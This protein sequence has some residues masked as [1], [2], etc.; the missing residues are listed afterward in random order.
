MVGLD[1]CHIHGGK[2]LRGPAHPHFTTGRYSTVLP[3]RLLARYRAAE[4][5]AELTPCVASSP[6]W[7]RA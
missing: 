5:D 3:T 7:M 6:S 1:V 4:K 2:S